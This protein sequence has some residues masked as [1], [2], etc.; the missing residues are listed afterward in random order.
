MVG[1]IGFVLIIVYVAGAWKFLRGF[2][3]TNFTQSRFLLALMWP[4]FLVNK[5][6]RQNFVKALKG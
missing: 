5:S 6:Y 3:R 1:L 2:D 4:I